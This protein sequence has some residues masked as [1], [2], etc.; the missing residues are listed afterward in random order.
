[1]AT[2][3]VKN[4]AGEW[5]DVSTS[6]LFG[7]LK[8]D[9]VEWGYGKHQKYIDLSQYVGY[10]DDFIIVLGVSTYQDDGTVNHFGWQK[11]SGLDHL[12]PFD[13]SLDGTKIIGNIFR[14]KAGSNVTISYDEDTRIFT[15][16]DDTYEWIYE[17]TILYSGLKEA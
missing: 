4:A 1:M 15:L 16:T 8:T 7:E 12:L 17:Y 9:T 3:K 6:K 14:E 11:S 5:V 13:S 2:M 10:G